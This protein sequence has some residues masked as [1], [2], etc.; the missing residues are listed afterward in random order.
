MFSAITVKQ[1]QNILSIFEKNKATEKIYIN[2]IEFEV[3]RLKDDLFKIYNQAKN[4]EIRILNK[5]ITDFKVETSKPDTVRE[6]SIA[7]TKFIEGKQVWKIT[8]T[9]EG[10]KRFSFNVTIN[11]ESVEDLKN[12]L[13]FV[14]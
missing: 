2:N 8:E 14:D 13:G 7:P 10:I 5:K 11:E 1:L 12:I 6:V 3:E 9:V 4:Y